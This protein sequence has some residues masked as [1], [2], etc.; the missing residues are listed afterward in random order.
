MKKLNPKSDNQSKYLEAIERNKIIF[1]N[2]PAGT[3]KTYMPSV[4]G[5]DALLDKKYDRMVIS[6]P[7]VQSDADSG[8]LPGELEDKLEPYMRP[9]LDVFGRSLR[10]GEIKLMIEKKQLELAPLGYMLGRSFYK[11]FII[12]DEMQNASFEQ[13]VLALT[14]FA[15]GSKMILTGDSM[16]SFL[17]PFKQGGFQKMM[18]KLEGI[19]GIGVIHMEHQDIV[20]EPI[21]KAILER[22]NETQGEDR[23]EGTDI[24]R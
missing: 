17:P 19:E 13:I 10:E 21:I 9:I 11:S 15:T 14:R 6:R 22:L 1:V 18:H 12:L 23:Q 8:F 24:K 20:R 5:L 7:M 2:G 16:Q 4:W 3:G